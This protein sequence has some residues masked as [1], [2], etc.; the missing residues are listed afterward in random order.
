MAE[1]DGIALPWC[2]L[3]ALSALRRMAL[4]EGINPPKNP[5]ASA[6]I[7]PTA[8]VLASTV[9][10]R[11][12]NFPP[13]FPPV[14]ILLAVKPSHSEPIA[15]PMAPP[16]RASTSD[17]SRNETRICHRLNPRSLSTPMSYVR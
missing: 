3:R 14:T 6:S 10:R 15:Q 8:I 17:S 7:I 5:M 11:T 4:T 13:P 16:T 2:Y 1:A 12:T 9:S